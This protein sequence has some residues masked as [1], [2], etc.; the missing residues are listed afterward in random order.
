MSSWNPFYRLYDPASRKI[1]IKEGASVDKQ[2]QRAET[3]AL[4]ESQ[5]TVR[6]ESAADSGRSHYS[7][8]IFPC[9]AHQIGERE[10]NQRD[11]CLPEKSALIVADPVQDPEKQQWQDDVET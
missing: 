10:D 2:K 1:L 6:A 8:H 3:A 5:T 4:E 11:K 9:V 7:I